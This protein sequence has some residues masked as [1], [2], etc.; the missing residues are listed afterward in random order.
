M[1]LALLFPGQ[2]SQKV[3]MGKQLAEEFPA[4][5]SV[6]EQADSALGMSLSRLCFEGPEEEL[7]LTANTQ[8]AI[9]TTSIAALRALQS[10]LAIAPELAA[11][12]SLGEYS[13]PG[14][15]RRD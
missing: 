5:R 6:F 1:K 3:G 2:G 7:R 15:C 4:A 9:L 11:G 13:C 10:Q 8:P 14:G 12:H